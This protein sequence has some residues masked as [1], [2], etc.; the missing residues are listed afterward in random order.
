MI[1]AQGLFGEEVGVDD[2][3]DVGDINAILAGSDNSEATLA[4]EGEDAWHDIFIT[5]PP[6]EMRPQR[7]GG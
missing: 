1:A 6:D 2:V 7:E 4:C 3:G 5:R